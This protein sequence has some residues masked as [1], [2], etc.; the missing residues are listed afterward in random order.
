L[1]AEKTGFPAYEGNGE[2]V[3]AMRI[4]SVDRFERIGHNGLCARLNFENGRMSEVF[5]AWA[6]AENPHAGDYLLV[7]D[8]GL[9]NCLSAEEFNQQYREIT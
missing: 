7:R 3:Y 4:K 6:D 9:P 1:K 2:T 8:K 5:P